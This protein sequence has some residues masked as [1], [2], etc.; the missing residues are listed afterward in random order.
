MIIAL[1]IFSGLLI[2]GIIMAILGIFGESKECLSFELFYFGA[3]CLGIT[4]LVGLFCAGLAVLVRYIF[5][6]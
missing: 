6:G 3:G 1:S 5:V 2:L 4:G